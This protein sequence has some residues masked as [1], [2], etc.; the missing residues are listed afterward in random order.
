MLNRSAHVGTLAAE[1]LQRLY[2]AAGLQGMGDSC[3]SCR[4]P[5]PKDDAS[6]LAMTQK[7]VD[8]GDAEATHFLG[9]QYYFGEWIEERAIELWTRAE[10][11]GS[12]MRTMILGAH[13]TVVLVTNRMN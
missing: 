2:K 5:L 1:N 4:T 9:S 6:K 10:E 12:P 8:G 11:L 3:P 7:R 13:T